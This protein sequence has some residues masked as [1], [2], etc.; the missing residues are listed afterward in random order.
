[1]NNQDLKNKIDNRYVPKPSSN[2]AYRIADAAKPKEKAGFGL[3]IDKVLGRFLMIPKPAYVAAFCLLLAVTAV[4]YIATPQETTP[5]DWE[6][7]FEMESED[8]L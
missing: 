8:W 5:V 3:S 6:L 7:F 4:F 2:L 1:M